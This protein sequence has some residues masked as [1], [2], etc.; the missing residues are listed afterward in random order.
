MA[1]RLRMASTDV[2]MPVSLPT[3]A[4]TRE[5]HCMDISPVTPIPKVAVLFFSP[6]KRL[7][8]HH[9]PS[10]GN[11]WN[12]KEKPIQCLEILN[13]FTESLAPA[14]NSGSGPGLPVAE[15]AEAR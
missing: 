8:F 5:V 11:H 1:H 7:L 14:P 13:P 6:A 2:V 3:S 10:I 4:G 9:V 15:S 12:F